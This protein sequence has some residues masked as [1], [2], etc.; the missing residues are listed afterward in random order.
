MYM[1]HRLHTLQL[2]CHQYRG[3]LYRHF[4]AFL[5]KKKSYIPHRTF[6]ITCVIIINVI[7]FCGVS[8]YLLFCQVILLRGAYWFLFA[9]LRGRATHS[10]YCPWYLLLSQVPE[11]QI[12][13]FLVVA[14][15]CLHTAIAIQQ[16]LGPGMGVYW[17]V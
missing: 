2:T 11:K 15:S 17:D 5:I 6:H 10:T 4:L 9:S 12:L 3:L 16:S 8:F 1:S 7:S 13:M 14:V